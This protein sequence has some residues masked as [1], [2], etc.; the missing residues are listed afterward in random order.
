MKQTLP[1]VP[2]LPR[3]SQ[4]LQRQ[5]LD[6]VLRCLQHVSKPLFS[7]FATATKKTQQALGLVQNA[8]PPF[9]CI[10]ISMVTILLQQSMLVFHLHWD[11]VSLSNQ[12]L[13][14]KTNMG[15]FKEKHS[16]NIHQTTC[17]CK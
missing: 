7:S 3:L 12:S 10:F 17:L 9:R 13:L 6:L 8:A 4:W 14:V 2:T 16:V 15:L 11:M 5:H 1:P